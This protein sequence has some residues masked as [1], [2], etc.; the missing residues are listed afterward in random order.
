MPVSCI[1]IFTVFFSLSAF[2]EILPFAGVYFIAFVTRL[3][4][5]IIIFFRSR[6]IGGSGV[7]GILREKSIFLSSACF[8]ECKKISC[9]IGSIFSIWRLKPSIPS[10]SRAT[11]NRSLT[12]PIR[13]VVD[14]S[15][16]FMILLCALLT[17]P[18]SS[19]ERACKVHLIPVRGVRSWWAAT[20][21]N[22]DFTASNC[23]NSTMAFSKLIFV[24][25]SSMF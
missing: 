4:R 9:S 13:Y 8:F 14:S 7:S 23:F 6:F 11:F 20:E 25:S 17:F 19:S 12:S 21:T 22:S 2:I 3:L 16:F 1:D 18:T 15:A 10:S 24:C 5:A